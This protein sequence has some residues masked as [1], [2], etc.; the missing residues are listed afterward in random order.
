MKKYCDDDWESCEHAK[1]LNEAYESIERGDLKAMEKQKI[2][3]MEKEMRKLAS[4]LGRVE[5]SLEAKEND[6]KELRKKSR[7]YED[8]SLEEYK[9]RRKL[10]HETSQK[11]KR[12]AME[13][14]KVTEIYED[15]MCYLIETY[16]N[17]KLKERD[18]QEWAKNKEVAIRFENEG[19]E[20][21]WL[22]LTRTV[23]ANEKK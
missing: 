12:L 3:A 23:G 18:V 14:Q 21:I 11:D 9:R 22:S 6:I 4:A 5:K 19:S 10:E 15:R 16:C 1:G 7:Y 17:G 20:R 8:R 2:K 13:L